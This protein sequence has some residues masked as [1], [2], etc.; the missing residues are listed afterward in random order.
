MSTILVTISNGITM[1]LM[2]TSVRAYDNKKLINLTQE[3]EKAKEFHS[4]KEAF[5]FISKCITNGRN[6]ITEPYKNKQPCKAH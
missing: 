4:S 3:I 6:F 1:Y 2:S 5:E